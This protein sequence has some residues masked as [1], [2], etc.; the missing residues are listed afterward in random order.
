[1]EPPIRLAAVALSSPPWAKDRPRA[2][3][4]EEQEVV[5]LEDFKVLHQAQILLSTPPHLRRPDRL[6]LD[7]VPHRTSV[8]PVS[9]HHPIPIQRVRH[10]MDQDL[11]QVLPS[12]PHRSLAGRTV[13][14]LRLAVEV[15][16]EGVDHN[17]AAWAQEECSDRE[18]HRTSI[19]RWDRW[20]LGL[21]T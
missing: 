7:L 12:V 19:R 16:A 4:A 13:L 21:L 6:R 11:V 8:E 2:V 18:V 5:D 20:A 3:A 1:M 15:V 10:T 14:A 9:R 17:L